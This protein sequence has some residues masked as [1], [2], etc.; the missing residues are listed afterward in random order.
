M[1]ILIA[2]D[3]KTGRACMFRFHDCDECNQKTGMKCVLK[4]DRLSNKYI[5]N[6]EDAEELWKKMVKDMNVKQ[7][8][9]PRFVYGDSTLKVR[10]SE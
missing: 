8:Q 3:Q 7:A 9:I 1:K 6:C 5:M 2:K 4:D 10:D